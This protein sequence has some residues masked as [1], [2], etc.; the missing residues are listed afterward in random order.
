MANLKNIVYLTKSQMNELI[1]SGQIVEDNVVIHTYDE[2]NDYRLKIDDVVEDVQING[3][4]INNNGVA[5]ISYATPSTLGVIKNGT[6]LTSSSG[7]L[8]LTS[9]TNAQ[10]SSRTSGYAIKTDVLD[11]AVKYALTDNVGASYTDNEKNN[12][13]TRINAQENINVYKIS[14]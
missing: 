8:T 7:T 4:S 12:A 9:P 10:I 5:N 13:R 2:N 3:T 11:V 1:N 6:G 14:Y